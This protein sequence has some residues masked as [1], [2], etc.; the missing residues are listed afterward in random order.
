MHGWYAKNFIQHL[1]NTSLS[2]LS[3]KLGC[4]PDIYW[5]K[6]ASFVFCHLLWLCN[7]GN[8][9]HSLSNLLD[10][11]Y[12]CASAEEVGHFKSRSWLTGCSWWFL[13]LGSDYHHP[14]LLPTKNLF[15][16]SFSFL[17]RHPA[18]LGRLV[19]C[20]GLTSVPVTTILMANEHSL[21]AKKA[22]RTLIKSRKEHIL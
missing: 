6:P 8:L 15:P 13:I 20:Y 14:L 1:S 21:S 18:V 4:C 3:G 7:V 17:T 19:T 5:R 16:S 9:S 2:S 12:I 10:S 11:K 22:H